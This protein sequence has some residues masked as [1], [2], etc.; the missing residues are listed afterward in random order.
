MH[1]RLKKGFRPPI[2]AAQRKSV[3]AMK[4]PDQPFFVK[5]KADNMKIGCDKIEKYT[6]Q[7]FKN[8]LAKMLNENQGLNEAFKD[9]DM[10]DIRIVS[11]YAKKMGTFEK[12]SI[13][14]MNS[15]HTQCKPEHAGCW[16][17]SLGKIC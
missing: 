17:K 9:P 10:P 2:G 8:V 1:V 4:R 5:V 14:P 12:N 3:N 11:K 13:E 6:D 16:K 15:F 7:Y